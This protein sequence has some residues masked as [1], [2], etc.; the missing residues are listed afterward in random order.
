MASSVSWA[1]LS[2]LQLLE[3]DNSLLLGVDGEAD[4]VSGPHPL[5]QRCWLNRIAHRHRLH[6]ALNLAMGQYEFATRGHHRD[7]LPVIPEN[8][9][10]LLSLTFPSYSRML[11]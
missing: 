3:C 10:L 8:P 6:K 5:E 7:D 11:D 1:A 2:W 9:K 4:R